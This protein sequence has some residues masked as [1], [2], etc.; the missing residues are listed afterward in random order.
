MSFQKSLDNLCIQVAQQAR[1]ET[2]EASHFAF[3]M[4]A[5]KEQLKV[6]DPKAKSY[7]V[8]MQLIDTNFR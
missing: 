4:A 1:Q 6:H 2:P 5:A 8:V 7:S 3:I